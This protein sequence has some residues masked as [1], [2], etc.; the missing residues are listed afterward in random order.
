MPTNVLYDARNDLDPHEVESVQITRVAQPPD[1]SETFEPL[2]LVE[3]QR[4]WVSG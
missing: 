4:R 3:V 1:R 2:E